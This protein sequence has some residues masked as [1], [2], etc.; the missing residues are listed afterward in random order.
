MWSFRTTLEMC[1]ASSSMFQKVIS[2]NTSRRVYARQKV[3][4]PE[5]LTG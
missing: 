1:F 3:S 5:M 2:S 4:K